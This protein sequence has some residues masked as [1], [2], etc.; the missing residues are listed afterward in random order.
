M[1]RIVQ[2]KFLWPLCLL[3]VFVSCKQNTVDSDAKIDQ[4][5]PDTVTGV[6][7]DVLFTFN[8]KTLNAG[9]VSD[10]P[11]SPEFALYVR[12]CADHKGDDSCVL[13][14]FGSGYYSSSYPYMTPIFQASK[15]SGHQFSLK[16][17]HIENAARGNPGGYS[18]KKLRALPKRIQDKDTP[19][20]EY[21]MEILLYEEDGISYDDYIG[22]DCKYFEDINSSAMFIINGKKNSKAVI[23]VSAGFRNDRI[24][25]DLDDFADDE[26]VLEERKGC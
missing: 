17:F 10:G 3:W 16:G 23:E 26:E 20:G 14:N 24:Q 13:T 7:E 4:S 12:I 18:T 5:S 8:W 15:F 19:F 9:N 21:Y 1:N 6:T 11:G 2:A 25:E 22:G